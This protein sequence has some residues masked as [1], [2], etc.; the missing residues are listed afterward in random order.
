MER[1]DVP[2]DPQ[3][4]SAKGGAGNK[5]RWKKII[6][7]AENGD[8]AWIKEHE[9]KVFVQFM[10]RL[11][12]LRTVRP[13]I[14]ETLANEWWVGPTGTGKS[15]LLWELYPEHYAKSL[16]KWWDGYARE[17]VVAIEE[18]APKNEVTGSFLKIWADRYP[19]KGEIKGGTLMHL[20]PKKIIILSN[21]TIE[22]C[23]LNDQDRLPLLRRFRVMRFPDD[24]PWARAAHMKLIQNQPQ[25]NEE[26]E[27]AT[28]SVGS[29]DQFDWNGIGLDDADNFAV[30]ENL[31]SFL[32][33]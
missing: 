23:F 30:N 3:V 15:R 11:D 17:D 27:E 33:E 2:T 16:N 8:V 32:D 14:L 12:G 6:E 24:I 21:Y 20:R 1:G 31:L 13:P 5:L 4:S 19:F 26:K 28:S 18:W 10:P 22:E 29:L 25:E 7:R 9:P